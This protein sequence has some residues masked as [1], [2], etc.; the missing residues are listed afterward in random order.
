MR[1][2]CT[3]E[4]IW[5]VQIG[6]GWRRWGEPSYS[7]QG[8][9]KWRKFYTAFW[10]RFQPNSPICGVPSVFHLWLEASCHSLALVSH[11]FTSSYLFGE[12]ILH[13]SP[14]VCLPEGKLERVKFVWWTTAPD[15]AVGLRLQLVLT[16]PFPPTQSVLNLPALPCHFGIFWLRIWWCDPNLHSWECECSMIIPSSGLC[17]HMYLVNGTREYQEVPN[18]KT[19]VPHVFLSSLLCKSSPTFSCHSE[20]LTLLVW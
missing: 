13:G 4:H 14:G 20:S 15:T 3:G 12:N 10:R 8:G 5:E 9:K 6:R 19:W 18:W 2:K 16:H 17:C 7:C 11:R 1:K